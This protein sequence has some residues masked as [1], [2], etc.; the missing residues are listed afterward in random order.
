M[1]ATLEDVAKKSGYSVSTVSRVL[2]NKGKV[3]R[4]KDET[5][6]KIHK[7][8]QELNYVPNQ[9]ARGLRLRK[10][11][12]IG[13]VI[14]DISNPFFAHVSRIIQIE[15]YKLGYTLIVCNTDEN[16]DTEIEQI[17]LLRSKGV[18]GFIIMP[19]GL[20]S[21]HIQELID[22]K[23]P[24]VLL[25][26]CFDSIDTNSVVVD[27]YTGSYKA[28]EYLIK[29]GH[30]RIAIIQGLPNTSTN[31]MRVKGYKNAL[32]K[33]NIE[34]D[35][36]LIVGNDYRRENGYIETKLLLKMSNPPTAIFSTSDLI[37]LG[38]LDAIIE[39]KLNVPQDVSLI[40]FDDV[41]FA[42][43][44][45]TPLT[46][47]QQPRQIMGEMAVKLLYDDLKSK[48]RKEKTRIE[49]KPVLNIRKSVRNLNSV[50]NPD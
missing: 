48:G 10:T 49:L 19:V 43:Y 40:S 13:L 15:S 23:I 35:E 7:I 16:Q 36:N 38:T 28:V 45:F 47:I 5:A 42:P 29:N 11:H 27:N 21:D 8:A 3:N 4:I 33:Y 22:D 39:E 25:D 18:D 17:Q 44:L 50:I 14:P 12:A 20:K 26:R 30:K 37:T 2:N 1:T 41:D 24:L 34:I 32:I 9:L 6:D 31:N 46:A